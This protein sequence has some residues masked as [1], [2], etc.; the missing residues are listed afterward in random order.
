M[1]PIKV[2][3]TGLRGYL[4]AAVDAGGRLDVTAGCSGRLEVPVGQLRSGIALVDLET[5]RRLDAPH[6]PWI[7]A[8][9]ERLDAGRPDGSYRATGSISLRDQTR[10][11]SGDLQITS[12]ADG[13]LEVAGERGFDVRELGLEPPRLL[14]LKVYPDVHVR[15][16]IEAEEVS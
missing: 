9:L 7:V 10:A 6:Y 11:Y 4:D 15:I 1:H 3:A 14:M 16:E 12:G 5:E 2:Q 8:Q 13:T